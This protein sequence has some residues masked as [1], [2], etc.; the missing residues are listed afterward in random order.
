MCQ[1][2]ACGWFFGCSCCCCFLIGRISYKG[3]VCILFCM[4]VL[5]LCVF[6][7]RVCCELFKNVI[8]LI[9]KTN[10]NLVEQKQ[11]RK[12]ERKNRWW[13]K[14]KYRMPLS[15]IIFKYIQKSVRESII[16]VHHTKMT[17]GLFVVSLLCN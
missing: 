16:F 15:R 9:K 5:C 2:R 10:A 4:Y 3:S 8:E 6:S 14:N 12:K 7:Q 13:I 1:R 17:G 11:N